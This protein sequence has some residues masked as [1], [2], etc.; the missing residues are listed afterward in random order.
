MSEPTEG[1]WRDEHALPLS[2]L[3]RAMATYAQDGQVDDLTG[4]DAGAEQE[5]GHGARA[6]EQD[7]ERRDTG[8]APA[9]PPEDPDATSAAGRRLR[10][11]PDGASP[12][13]RTGPH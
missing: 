8:G 13:G 7:S 4:E 10:P 6:E 1:V 12:F 11:S 5:F 3:T 2:E 9:D